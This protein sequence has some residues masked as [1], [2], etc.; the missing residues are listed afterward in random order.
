VKNV[1]TKVKDIYTGTTEFLWP[2]SPCYDP[3]NW[4]KERKTMKR[5]VI[6]WS[7]GCDFKDTYDEH[8]LALIAAWAEHKFGPTGAMWTI[9]G[10]HFYA[11]CEKKREGETWPDGEED[12]RERIDDL[13]ESMTRYHG[14]ILKKG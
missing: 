1:Y 8:V 14:G 6:T 12:L 2:N 11:K 3:A 5:L 7:E 10:R 4:G 13:E 9:P